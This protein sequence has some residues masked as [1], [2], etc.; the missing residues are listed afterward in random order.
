MTDYLIASLWTPLGPIPVIRKPRIPI[1]RSPSKE[2]LGYEV[3]N[4]IEDD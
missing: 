3:G 4:L 1:P 2:V